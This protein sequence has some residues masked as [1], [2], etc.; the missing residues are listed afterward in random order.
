MDNKERIE[1]V[2]LELNTKIIPKI[3]K[4]IKNINNGGCGIFAYLLIKKLNSLGIKASAR[5]IEN[6]AE[7][8]EVTKGDDVESFKLKDTVHSASNYF[9]TLLETKDI[10]KAED[11]ANPVWSHI[12]VSIV[13]DENHFYLID[14]NK[15]IKMDH[16]KIG[17][18][19]FENLHPNMD[20]SL[21]NM[22]KI[23]ASLTGD[24]SNYYNF[25]G[26]EIDFNLLEEITRNNAP[27]FWNKKFKKEQIPLLKEIIEELV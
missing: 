18:N 22:G 17:E 14:G 19:I 26:D 8:T 4:N 2:I 20:K 16:L 10:N 15:I 27:Y 1:E 12:L 7:G 13:E 25:L 24:E 11:I 21:L 9:K 5:E 23:I 6:F 3:E